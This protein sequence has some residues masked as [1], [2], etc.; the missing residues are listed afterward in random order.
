MPNSKPDAP[1]QIER[2]RFIGQLAVAIIARTALN[3]ARR[4]PYTYASVLARGLGVHLSAITSLIAL[5]QATSIFAPI[6]GPLGDRHGYR[7]MMLTG[8]ALLS[9]MALV[10]F[11]PLYGFVL[12]A[13]ALASLG[14]NIFD[15]ALQAYVGQRVSYKNRGKTI[16]AIELAWAGSTLVG[17]PLVGL[18]IENYGWQAPFTVL[19][20]LG[21]AGFAVLH[22]AIPAAPPQRATGATPLRSRQAWKMLAQ[23]PGARW[24]LATGFLISAANDVLF[25]IYGAWLE[26]SFSLGI[27]A[28]GTATM[29]IGIAEVCGE[30][31]TALLADKIGLRRSLVIGVVISAGAFLLLP[32]AGGSLPLA[33][34]GLFLVFVSYE[35]TVVTS[36]SLFTEV[37]PE[38][39]ATMMSTYFAAAGLGRVAGASLGGVLWLT[40]GLT[41]TTAICALI[42]IAAWGCLRR[43]GKKWDSRDK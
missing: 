4:F 11:F 29:V 40:S 38:A 5:S 12:M 26:Q 20:G 14:K 3:T 41:V 24:A 34:G 18:L 10:G 9:G 25:V 22:R 17:I 33:L 8:M 31:L 13:I 23:N 16:G 15:P 21:I 42:N 2:R 37:M 6:F 28:L 39:R 1:G 43:F 32:L 27:V 36:F 19:G 7:V 30:G 35:F